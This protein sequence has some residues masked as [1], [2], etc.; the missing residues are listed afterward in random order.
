[1][2]KF[3]SEG[4]IGAGVRRVEAIVGVDAYRFLASEHLLL[5]QLS[6]L[7]KARP[8]ELPERIDAALTRLK[9][10][11]REIAK[12]RSAA[13][14]ANLD[15]L[16]G[17]GQEVGDVRVW[18]FAA[19]EGT[20]AGGLRELVT[21]GR[22]KAPRE[23]PGAGHARYGGAGRQSGGPARWACSV[24]RTWPRTFW[25]PPLLGTSTVMILQ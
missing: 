10:A 16:L 8:E 15:G 4:S 19:P 25:R 7:V 3:L 22:D 17:A 5:A 18:T 1:V 24:E 21:K 23:A 6:D 13:M 20:D 12:H 11:E 9:D 14:V 2:V